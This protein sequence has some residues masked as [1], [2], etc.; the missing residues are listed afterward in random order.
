MFAHVYCIINSIKKYWLLSLALLAPWMCKAQDYTGDTLLNVL[1]SELDYYKEK[2]SKREVPAY[3]LSFR[4]E[5]FFYQRVESEFGL[6]SYS[7][8]HTRLFYPQV[9]V[10]DSQ[11]D[12]YM[13]V[14]QSRGSKCALPF[15][16]SSIPAVKEMVWKCV[17]DN[18]QKA[19]DTYTKMKADSK[20][21][22]SPLDSIPSFTTVP[23]SCYYEEPFT[24]GDVRF[25]RDRWQAYA[26][27]ASCEFKQYKEL[28]EGNVRLISEVSRN[29][30][31]NTEGTVVAQNRIA[32][33]LMVTASAKADDDTDCRIMEDCFA[34]S[35]DEIPSQDSLKQMVHSVARRAIALSQ[36]PVADPY[37]G[38]ALIAGASSGVFFHEVLGH[39][40]EGNRSTT[41][42][43]EINSMVGRRIL[44]TS[45]QIYCDPTLNDY[46]NLSLNGHYLYDDEGT[47][48]Q[49]V[50]CVRDGVLQQLLMSRTPVMGFSGTNG[51]ARAE[52]G[53]DPNPRQSN[54]VVE[55]SDYHSEAQLRQM[56]ISELK[57]QKLEYGYLFATASN[58]YT[59][60][61]GRSNINSFN[62][63]PVE[64]Y[65]VFADG[66]PDQLVRGVSLI[67]T[68]LAMFSNIQAAGGHME[69]FI[70]YCGSQSGQVPVAAV[71]PMLYVAQVETQGKKST[72]VSKMEEFDTPDV[73]IVAPQSDTDIVF[74]AMQDEMRHVEQQLT[75]RK[76]DAPLLIDYTLRRESSSHFSSTLGSCYE[77]S[78]D[79]QNNHLT[80]WVE[81]GDSLRSTGRSYEFDNLP[82]TMEYADLRAKLRKGSAYAYQGAVSRWAEYQQKLKKITI[83]EAEDTIPDFVH[84]PAV[85]AVASSSWSHRA[86]PEQLKALA[87]RLS[88]LFCDYPDLYRTWVYVKQVC[89][90]H[91]RFT[92]E[93]LKIL[94]PETYLNVEVH[95]SVRITKGTYSSASHTI[96]VYDLAHLDMEDAE[97]QV[98]QFA[99]ALLLR[100]K[101]ESQEDFYV[102]PVM[103]ED[104]HVVNM[105]GWNPLR[106]LVHP[107]RSVQ[108]NIFENKQMFLDK[109]LFSD[110][111]T[112]SQF[113]DSIVEGQRMVGY[114][115]TDATGIAP[116]PVTIVDKGFF[117]H[118]LSGRRPVRG[119]MTSTG[120]ENF[121]RSWKGDISINFAFNG[122]YRIKFSRTMPH[123]QLRKQLLR[124]ARKAGN[125]YA[126]IIRYGQVVRVDVESNAETFVSVKNVPLLTR[127]EQRNVVAASH[128]NNVLN[129]EGDSFGYNR[130]AG[131]VAPKA[132]LVDNVELTLNAS[133]GISSDASLFELRH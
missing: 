131:W 48:A 128:E 101:A 115:H 32:Y 1:R 73:T 57:R 117:R 46:N 122:L 84:L 106:S 129:V 42:N 37:T 36:A 85:E 3:F 125:S 6:G 21:T 30:I 66:R 109:R 49:R 78:A 86:K 98:R 77:V 91:Y 93:G 79:R 38:P 124:L 2:L 100:A 54:L 26:D 17:T 29:L 20:N 127:S 23:A 59:Y 13:Y 130:G 108:R 121:G 64:V 87:N 110:M 25:D 39:R 40:L 19:V 5:D 89:T 104:V 102:G 74:Q 118:M 111:L 47:K 55:S 90:D 10:G 133:T 83:P 67:G 92:S 68:P 33:R 65:R 8:S 7:E 22:S 11:C 70:G 52:Q 53:K 62:V 94:L 105:F 99:D 51:H 123:S 61:S 28:S 58:G 116:K 69:R 45:F 27:A 97:C 71:A 44:P 76:K 80:V 63:N 50:D 81:M 96:R 95:A 72:T 31:L 103:Y 14:A 113:N 12:N 16:C 107:Q 112:I 43:A 18:Y 15:N 9:R 75:N 24:L 60:M 82:Q 41:V 132:V 4:T 114:R 34:Y 126:Y 56:L 35:L 119:C 120:N 88:A